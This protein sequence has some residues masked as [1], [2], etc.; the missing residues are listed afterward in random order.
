MM[1][2]NNTV[3][4]HDINDIRQRMSKIGTKVRAGKLTHL[5]INIQ[6]D[7]L[8]KTPH[9]Q[10][11]V[12]IISLGIFAAGKFFIA[13]VFLVTV[14][15]LTLAVRKSVSAYVKRSNYEKMMSDDDI[16][17]LCENQRIKEK[18][19]LVLSSGSDLTY[20]KALELGGALE[21]DFAENIAMQKRTAILDKIKER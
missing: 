20:G 5:C 11:F 4:E 16:N 7:N 21:A 3:T 8:G 1:N 17:Y 18:V 2:P 6:S 15:L 12:G 14:Y 10:L 19:I 13:I 9:F